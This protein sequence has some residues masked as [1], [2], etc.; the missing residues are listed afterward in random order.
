MV[1]P[2]TKSETK[3]EAAPSAAPEVKKEEKKPEPK[4]LFGQRR[5][6]DAEYIYKEANDNSQKTW[7]F[8][9]GTLVDIK[10]PGTD[11]WV[12]IADSE[13]RGGWVRLEK[14]EEVK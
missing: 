6:K 9:K 1:Q 2:Q 4:A 13:S 3:T 8:K 7:Q 14:L 10:Q 5:L 12:R 11:G